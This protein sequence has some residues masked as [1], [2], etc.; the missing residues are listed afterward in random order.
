VNKGVRA[1]REV[2]AQLRARAEST[3]ESNAL[4]LRL[5]DVK[6][7]AGWLD[8]ADDW[9]WQTGCARTFSSPRDFGVLEEASA[10][11]ILLPYDGASAITALI[12]FLTRYQRGDFPFEDSRTFP[13]SSGS[14][15]S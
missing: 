5:R 4:W 11:A 7:L 14:P 10:E 15:E 1:L 8:G 9:E 3:P 6:S 13:Q 12:T 2:E